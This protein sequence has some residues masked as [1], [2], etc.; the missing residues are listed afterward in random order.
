MIKIIRVLVVALCFATGIFLGQA[1]NAAGFPPVVCVSAGGVAGGL[2]AV[3]FLR[4]VR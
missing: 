4:L 3:I 2:L 1:M